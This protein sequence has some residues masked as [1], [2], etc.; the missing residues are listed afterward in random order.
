[1]VAKSVGDLI[2]LFDDDKR[3]ATFARSFLG[4]YLVPALGVLPKT[5]IDLLV[6]TLM[7][8][9][10]AIDPNG[11]IFTL[12]R[13]L[14]ITPTKTRSLIFQYQLRQLVRPCPVSDGPTHRNPDPGLPGGAGRT[15][16][17]VR[18]RSG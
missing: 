8:D 13:S 15:G 14:N 3:A 12:A 6:F 16:S 1:M 7:V 18:R 5:E 9:A 17:G 2:S 4:S 10:G 11:S